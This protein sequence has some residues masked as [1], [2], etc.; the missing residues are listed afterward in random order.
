MQMAREILYR[1]CYG[2]NQV[3][4]DPVLTM[5]AENLS[6]RPAIL[7]NYCRH[8]VRDCDYP[9]II[10]EKGQSVRGTYVTGLTDGDM[11]RLD[12]FEGSEYS[13]QKV[14]VEVLEDDSHSS[15]QEM[16]ANTYVFTAGDDLLEKIEWN[17]DEFRAEKL[18]RWTGESYEYHGEFPERHEVMRKSS[19]IQKMLM[20]L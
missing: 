10:P 20:R 7:H 8:R 2:P 12:T 4:K 6:I 19:D 3:G 14:K 13:K 15:G 17:Y 5:L 1:V 16:E 18:H 11:Y 9:G